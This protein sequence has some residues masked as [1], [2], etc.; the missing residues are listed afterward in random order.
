MLFNRLHKIGVVRQFDSEQLIFVRI[1]TVIND[2]LLSVWFKKAKCMVIGT[3]QKLHHGSR[4]S[5]VYI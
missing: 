3:A 5:M 2:N 1:W 4:N